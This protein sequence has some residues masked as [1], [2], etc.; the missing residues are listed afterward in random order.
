[1][2]CVT[3]DLCLKVL[4]Q[5]NTRFAN[6]LARFAG[7]PVLG[8]EEEVGALLL[9]ETTLHSV[10]TLLQSGVQ[11]SNDVDVREELDRYTTHL[12]RLR[13]ELAI[14]QDSA[15]DCRERLLARQKHLNTAQAWCAAS[16]ATQ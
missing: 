5:A 2:E 3:T 1:M 9:L 12:L 6:F 4:R 10:R 7:V 16:R 14:M 15:A 8:S 13:G 11:G